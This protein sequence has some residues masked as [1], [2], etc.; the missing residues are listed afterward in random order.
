[1]TALLSVLERRPAHQRTVAIKQHD[2]GGDAAALDD[3]FSSILR[4][5]RH[6][7]AER[8]AFGLRQRKSFGSIVRGDDAR[9]Q[10]RGAARGLGETRQQ[11]AVDLTAPGVKIG[12]ALRELGH[13]AEAAGD[14]HPRH[15]MITQ[16]FQHAADEIAHVDQRNVR[17]AVKLLHRSFGI[18]ASAAGNVGKTG[19][20]RDIDTAMDRVN[21]RRAGIRHDDPGRAEDRQAADNAEAPVERFRRQFHA[22]G[23]G[24]LDLGVGCASGRGCNFGDGVVDHAARHRVDGRLARRKRKARPR[25]R[26]DALT[27]SEGHARSSR[28]SAHGG[29]N[30]R[31]VRYIRIVAGVLD[32][33]GACAGS[34]LS[35]HR[36]RKTWPLAARQSHLDRIGKFARYERGKRRLAAAAAQVP[37]VQP[38]RNGRSC[39]SMLLPL[40]LRPAVVTTGAA[41]MTVWD[42]LAVRRDGVPVFTP[43]HV[44]LAGAG[45]GDPG[46]LTLDALAGLQQADMVV[47]DA[48]VDQRV[49]AL[50]GPLARLEFAGKRGGKPSATQADISLRLITLARAGKRVLRLKGGDP[51]VF[52]A[53]A[54]RQWRSLPRASP[55]GSF[56]ASPLA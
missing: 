2:L 4:R 23:N 32:H 13:L 29:N 36:Q 25:H 18:G 19:G 28:A 50:A 45:P 24:D 20:A 1:M 54:K 33:A 56:P 31:T 40:I 17:Q 26:A 39:R 44:W 55:S 34:I 27:G 8:Y 9:T 52:G 14:G 42:S 10:L 30:E 43:G 41:V 5:A 49:L 46:P 53:A 16:I 47:H 12:E 3:A 22:A 11:R 7:V 15:R 21:P 51:F 6:R 35:R 37:V 48:L 38:R